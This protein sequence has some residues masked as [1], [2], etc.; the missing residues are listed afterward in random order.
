MKNY[1]RLFKLSMVLTSLGIFF[2]TMMIFIVLV[3]KRDY[4]DIEKNAFS[5]VF[6]KFPLWLALAIACYIPGLSGMY[7]ANKLK[8]KAREE[9]LKID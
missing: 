7:Y 3:Y 9:S 8:E 2:M 5:N 4:P 1:K 6:L